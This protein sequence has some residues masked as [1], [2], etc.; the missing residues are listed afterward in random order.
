MSALLPGKRISEGKAPEITTLR[1]VRRVADRYVRAID[2]F[3]REAKSH[4]S[5]A[6][7]IVREKVAVL[8]VG[9]VKAKVVHHCWC[10]RRR[11]ADHSLVREVLVPKP[12]RW[13]RCTTVGSESL[14]LI[15]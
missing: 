12:V 8:P 2:L 14:V 11:D 6:S 9:V 3:L 10:K 13:Q 15:V 5:R 4:A 7:V 1:S